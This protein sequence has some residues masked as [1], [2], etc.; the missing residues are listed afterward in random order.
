MPR[1]DHAARMQVA[2]RLVILLAFGVTVPVAIAAPALAERWTASDPRGDV[3]GYQLDPEP[4]PC[5]TATDVDASDNTTT[6]ITRLAVRHTQEYVLVTVRFRNLLRGDHHTWV[7]LRTGDR[8][9]Y[10]ISIDRLTNGS[11]VADL[12]REPPPTPPGNEGCV[13][14]VVAVVECD[15]LSVGHHVAH[16]YVLVRI[17][18]DCIGRPG[19]IRAGAESHRHKDGTF[20]SD[21]WAPPG[22]RANFWP[23]PFGP[24]VHRG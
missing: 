20:Y 6:D 7:H 17:P 3:S 11:L 21:R 1:S 13:E 24:R 23:G 12:Y 9:G 22:S 10:G 8:D 19:F 14:R 18:R 5:G 15:P 2:S 4:A 16:D